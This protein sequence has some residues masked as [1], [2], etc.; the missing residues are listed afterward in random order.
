MLLQ[1]LN[2]P[3]VVELSSIFLY[4]RVEYLHIMRKLHSDSLSC[5]LLLLDRISFSRRKG[6]N[7]YIKL[8]KRIILE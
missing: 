1:L 4:L 5:S 6:N 2:C 7:S 8:E 3:L